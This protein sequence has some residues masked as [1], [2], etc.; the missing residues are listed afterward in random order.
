MSCQQ[1]HTQLLYEIVLALGA[2]LDLQPMLKKSL[3]TMLPKLD[4]TGAAVLAERREGGRCWREEVY[5]APDS[6]LQSPAYIAAVADLRLTGPHLSGPTPH[7]DYTVRQVGDLHYCRFSLPG[8]GHLML[9]GSRPPDPDLV[10]S[11]QPICQRL[12]VCCIACESAATADD[13][14]HRTAP[15]ENHSQ[16]SINCKLAEDAL[17]SSEERFR[18]LADMLPEGLFETDQNLKLTYVNRHALELLGYTAED[19]GAGLNGL[20]LLV[21]EHRDL[22]QVNFARRLGGEDLGP[23]EY[24]ALTKNGSRIPIHFHAGPIMITGKLVGLRGMVV[25]ITE[26]KRAEEALR[27]SEEKLNTLLDATSEIVFLVKPDGTLLAINDAMAQS[28]GREKSELLGT[29][30]FEAAPPEIA[31]DRVARLRSAVASRKP[32]HGEV[33]LAGR[34]FDHS[35]YPIL[36]DDG[37]VNQVAVFAKDITER[38]L[39]EEE[40]ALLEE[41]CNQAEKVESIGRLAGGVAHDLNNLLTP[42]LGYGE[43]LLTDLGSD[44]KRREAVDEIL[45]AGFRA[46]DLVRRLLAFGRK[47]LLEYKPVDMNQAVSGFEQL[48]RRTIREDIQ[49]KVIRS[50]DLPSVL[51]DIGQMEQVIMNLAVNAADAMPEGGHLIIET[52]PATLNQEY[53]AK[54]EGVAPGEYVL[55]SVS[56]TGCGMDVELR[57]HVFEPFFSTKGDQGTGLG[58]AT[59]YGIVKQ[60]GGNIWVYSEPGKGTTFKIYLPVSRDASVKT[61]IANKTASDMRG[62]ETILLVEDNEHVRNLTHTILQRKGYTVL[63]AE[64]GPEALTILASCGV[65]VHMLVTD[66]VMPHMNGR[67]LYQ[68]AAREHPDLKV[69]YMSGYA[70]G[71][72]AHRRVLEEGA[73]FIQKPFTVPALAGKIREVLEQE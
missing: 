18:D 22:A 26:R 9:F 40:K 61:Q 39:L 32:L 37:N 38:K 5:V 4:C 25:D 41:R 11:F 8:Y 3:G 21:P 16:D 55:L 49:I 71:I 51:A 43:I 72:I 19:L 58:L 13:Q 24:I 57:E 34:F 1:E 14:A 31:D 17:R 54:H 66:M 12:A 46:R 45:K 64:N 15:E 20:D 70:G 2:S 7:S 63:A 69:L 65:P 6:T 59:V 50:P 67:E 35:V 48:L 73:A 36:D 23:V 52:A 33:S 42:I 30:V 56:D 10:H 29:N 27:E 44:D 47:Q 28:L 53:A 62:S 60:H 68:K